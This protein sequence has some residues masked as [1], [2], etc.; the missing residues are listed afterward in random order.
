MPVRVRLSVVLAV[1]LA[2]AAP[3]AADAA[4]PFARCKANKG[5]AGLLCGRVAVPL[6]RSGAMP[7]TINLHIERLP[8]KAFA[9]APPVFA[10]AGGPGQSA[11]SVTFE[12]AR[13]L[14]PALLTRDLVV[15]DQ[16]GTGLSGALRCWPFSSFDI[17]TTREATEAIA[18]CGG[19]LGRRAAHYSTAETVEDVEAVRAALG[20]DRIAL[21]GVSYGT[22]VALAYAARYPEH[23]ERLVLDSVVR[24][25]GP[26]PLWRSSFA[27]VPR[28]LRAVCGRRCPF[29]ADPAADIA[30]LVRRMS[31]GPLTGTVVR[32]DG[33]PHPARIGRADL[34]ALLVDA[35]FYPGARKDLPAAVSSAVAGDLAP[36]LR[37]REDAWFGF[38]GPNRHFSPATYLATMCADAALPWAQDASP[39]RRTDAARAYVEDL[40]AADFAP[41]D[42]T[43]G[44]AV[45]TLALCR[46]WPVA[47]RA[48]ATE[49]ALPDVPALLLAGTEDLRTPLEDARAVAALLPHARVLAVRGAGHSVVSL[50]RPCV[51]GAVAAF[52]GR[53]ASRGCTALPRPVPGRPVP[54][55]LAAVGGTP[56]A[57]ILAATLL[58]VEDALRRLPSARSGVNVTVEDEGEVW[59]LTVRPEFFFR[60]GGLRGGRFSASQR[61]LR[62]ERV[63]YVPGVVVDGRIEGSVDPFSGTIRRARGTLRVWTG[64]QH[65]TVS[66]R[67]GVAVLRLGGARVRLPFRA[68]AA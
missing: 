49:P 59:T 57:R 46:N 30:E 24:Q 17:R 54:R 41:F 16:R 52:L 26:D 6:D 13:V 65:G 66:I 4:D 39:P 12:F 63:V 7:G 23:V 11:S 50:G 67:R 56:R 62:L 61:M 51:D 53:R 29:T 35:D 44:L 60:A 37:I 9:A 20:A 21:M 58:T 3:A 48:E 2:A 10:F 28:V 47:G 38:A 1:A 8:A 40:P 55:S 68:R 36:L 19:S 31:G 34:F 22:K 18:A 42:A 33:R 27:A 64:G 25:D 43:T 5:R 14:G 45:G 15:L 32:G